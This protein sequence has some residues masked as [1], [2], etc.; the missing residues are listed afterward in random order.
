MTIEAK[1]KEVQ[2]IQA[3]RRSVTD[4]QQNSEQIVAKVE[5]LTEQLT[6]LSQRQEIASKAKVRRNF[7]SLHS[8]N[9]VQ[10]LNVYIIILKLFLFA[11]L[12]CC[13][14]MNLFIIGGVRQ[15]CERLE[16]TH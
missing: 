15:Q 16:R 13:L 8:F 2:E 9:R 10:F 14:E 5:R 12:L 3:M 4:C 1:D 7:L 6:K 11:L